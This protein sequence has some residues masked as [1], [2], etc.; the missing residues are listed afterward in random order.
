MTVKHVSLEEDFAEVDMHYGSQR[1]VQY[2]KFSKSISHG[3][4]PSPLGI[5]YRS[6]V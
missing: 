2:I 4:V 5:N 6:S 1:R 3:V